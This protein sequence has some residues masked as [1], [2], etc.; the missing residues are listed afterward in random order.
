MKSSDEILIESVNT[1]ATTVKGLNR[2]NKSLA[3]S[4]D[5]LIDAV[6]GLAG[7]VEIQKEEIQNLKSRI[8]AL[9]K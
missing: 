9:E 7:I 5:L 2:S 4:T 1:L 3:G 8:S 6:E